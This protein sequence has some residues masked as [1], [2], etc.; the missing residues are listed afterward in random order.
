[1]RKLNRFS[2]VIIFSS[3][4]S[5]QN[6]RSQVTI[7]PDDSAGIYET[8]ETAY[9]TI[10]LEGD[11]EPDSVR[12]MMKKGGHL[13]ADQ[14][15]LKFENNDSRLSYTFDSPGTVLLEVRW[16]SGN[17]RSNRTVGGALADPEKL[18]LSSQKPD[19]F[20]TYWKGKIA[21]LQTVPANPVL[22]IGASGNPEIGYWKISMNNIRGSHIQGQIARPVK[23]KKFP[24][25]LIVQWAG[26]YPLQKDWILNRA[27]DG[28]LVVNIEAHD[29]PIDEIQEFYKEQ[30]NGPLKNYWA[31]GN[32]DRE[33]CYFLRMYLSCF[34][35]AQYLTERPDWNGKTL[36]VMGDSQG[37]MQSIM[38]A[39]LHPDITAAIA[40]VPAGF[41]MLGP[42]IGR[43]GGWPQWYDQTVGKEPVKVH[44][45]SRYFDVSNFVPAIKCPVLVGVGLLDETC[46]PEGII[47]ALNQLSGLKEVVILPRSGHQDK[48]GSQAAFRDT[49]DKIWFP[50][51]RKGKIPKIHAIR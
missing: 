20:D 12:Y 17:N 39:G 3:L 1:M 44:E 33:N 18:K 31:I 37:G 36:V 11:Q 10:T 13:I 8:G 48:N 9:W 7:T 47:A 26:V 21:E 22:E 38:T 2:L 14:G 23:G 40:L 51:L 50:A 5:I 29:L 45:T 28:W 27:A 32:D 41:D 46:P 25:L 4:F 15:H 24:G 6:A 35:A 19:D 43:R 16:G 42:D 30:A 34:R 49:R